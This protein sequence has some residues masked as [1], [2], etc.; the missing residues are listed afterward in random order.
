MLSEYWMI[1][2]GALRIG[3][4]RAC[5]RDSKSNHIGFVHLGMSFCFPD[6]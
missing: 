5:I 1:Q 3:S 6:E 4:N 2:V